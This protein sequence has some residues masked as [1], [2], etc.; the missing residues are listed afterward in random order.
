[1]SKTFLKIGL[2]MLA[3]ALATGAD[4]A[5]TATTTLHGHV[6]SVVS[7]LATTGRLAATNQMHL[8]IGLPLRNQDGLEALLAQ[9]NDPTNPNY[10]H[11]LT[12]E[13]FTAQ[14]GPTE[15]EYQAVE[16]Y[17]TANGFTVSARHPNRMLL[18]VDAPATN[19]ERAFNVNF[20]TYN[21]PTDN[22]S[23]FAPDK[24]PSVP[25]ALKILDV[26]GM[27]NYFKPQP[28]IKLHTA[29]NRPGFTRTLGGTAPDG[30]SYMGTDYRKA[31]VPG[32]TLTG[33]GQKVALLQFDG[34][35][36]TDIAAYQALTGLPAIAITNILLD[37]FNGLPTLTGGEGEVELDI[38]MVNSMAPGIS[39]VLVYEENPA[40]FNPVTILNRI[41]NDNAAKQIS[42]SWSLG[43]SPS[44]SS[45]INHIL[46]Q[47]ALQ[48]QSFFQASGDSSALPPGQADSSFFGIC[49]NPYVTSCGGTKLNTDVSGNFISDSVWNDHIPNLGQGGNW[50]SGGGISTFYTTPSWQVG[51]GTST[52]HGSATGRNFPD[53]AFTATDI[54]IIVYG[55]GQVSG[56]TSAAAPL[57]AGYMALVNQQCA[58]SGKN[59]I[60]F[61][62]PQIYALASTSAYTNYFRDTVLGDNT[63]SGS[64][65]NFF[66]V[67]G[68]DLATGLGTPN[69]TNLINAL[70]GS[71]LN[72]IIVSAPVSPWGSTLSAMNGSNPNGEWFLFVQDDKQLDVGMINNGWSV[73]LTTA[74]PVGFAADSQIY[75]SATNIVVAPGT[76]FS[77][78]I[79]VTNYGPSIAT[80]VY[81]TDTL[82]STGVT[83]TSSNTTLGTVSSFGS[84]LTW[85][86][87]NLAVNAGGKLTLN[88]AAPVAGTYANIPLVNS[89]TYDPNQDDNTAATAI[90]VGVVSP[91]VFSV[92]NNAGGQF[93]FN[94]SGAPGSSVIIQASTNLVNW[95][96]IY[97]NVSPFS[98]TDSNST[99][100][101]YRFYRA[102]TGP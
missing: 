21:H 45:T 100:Y 51:F 58:A 65:T 74:N 86:L 34:Y 44:G 5:V 19:V 50:G 54:Y 24:E 18:Q 20:R 28:L 73:T 6:P 36:P 37:G 64:P 2:G 78:S 98:F 15:A 42:C 35:F 84:A 9:I 95:V 61:L 72:P 66:A 13:E 88:F 46:Q 59:P 7:T 31:Y 67:P 97:T 32:T 10:H 76:N 52:N 69:G 83:L 1:M 30:T 87:G 4:A 27:N 12:P 85:T 38:E 11:Y 43:V 101:P 16:N 8:A 91:P 22:R 94:L 96:P 77:L 93:T 23:F 39:Q 55:I 80:N 63:W 41:A 49:C 53:V 79:C 26:G 68:Y 57:W 48:G 90:T 33:A 89:T 40:I 92:T 17:A 47:M 102:V 82:P 81:V 99:N 62:N 14:F 56:G 71:T 70:A 60:G 29:T 75:V 25:A 3:V